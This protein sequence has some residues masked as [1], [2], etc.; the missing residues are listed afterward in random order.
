MTSN[1]SSNKTKA[2]V[3]RDVT[4]SVGLQSELVEE[5]AGTQAAFHESEERFRSAFDH[6]A[7]GMAIV[8]LDGRWIQVNRAIC[9]IVG[10]SEAELL[11]TNFQSITHPDD[12]DSNLEL[13]DQLIAGQIEDYQ[14][15]KRYF[16]KQGHI[17]WAL[18]SVSLVRD[19][20]GC[21]LYF[22]SQIQDITELQKTEALRKSEED[23]RTI[24]ELN[25]VGMMDADVM[26]RRFL[27]VNRKFCE[28]TGYSSEELLG[29]TIDQ[30]THP[31]DLAISLEAAGQ[32]LGGEIKSRTLEK[33]YIRKDGG[34]IWGLVNIAIIR[35]TPGSPLRA[36]A[37]VQDITRRKLSEE[38]ESGRRKILE[39]LIKGA[40]LPV[41]L[42]E[43]VLTLERQVLGT[44]AAFLPLTDGN[45]SVTGANLPRALLDQLSQWTLSRSI[46]LSAVAWSSENHCGHFLLQSDPLWTDCET[47]ARQNHLHSVWC[48]PIVA[49][50]GP[51]GLLLLF[52]GFSRRPLPHEVDSIDAANKLLTVCLEH[53]HASAGLAKAKEAAESAS[54]AKTQFL[55]HMSHEIRTPLTAIL[56]FADLVLTPESREDP[57]EFAHTV[58]RNGEHLLAIINDILD[59]SKIE[60]GQLSIEQVPTNIPLLLGELVPLMRQRACM[61]G[62]SLDVHF[63][64]GVPETIKSD[65]TRIR[66]ILLNLLGN[67]IKFTDHGG[68][69]I[70]LRIDESTEAFPML[71]IDIQDT[72]IGMTPEQSSRV[73]ASF[74]QADT[75]H[76]RLYGGTGLG[77]SISRRLANLM[78]GDIQVTTTTHVGST[79]TLSIPAI[80]LNGGRRVNEIETVAVADDSNPNSRPAGNSKRCVG[81]ILLAEDSPANQRLIATYLRNAGATV[82]IVENGRAAIESAT[83]ALRGGAPYDLILMDCQMPEMDGYAATRALRQGG[84]DRPIVAL[85]AHAMSHDRDQCLAAGSND[86][87]TKPLQLETFFQVVERHVNKLPRSLPTSPPPQPA[88]DVTNRIYSE[89]GDHPLIGPLIEQYLIGLQNKVQAVIQAVSSRDLNVVSA[90]AHQIKGDAGSYGFPSITRA[91]QVVEEIAKSGRTMEIVSEAVG[92]LAEVCRQASV[93][94]P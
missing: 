74:V 89:L 72:G 56:G 5:S 31:E 13:V 54:A 75:S 9:K 50:G 29:L 36:V 80:P 48:S 55:A 90:L 28:M 51:H 19:K 91:A 88:S 14:M 84:Y 16:H 64:T 57:H 8:G 66:Q 41:L 93:K 94:T 52:S 23:Y 87:L 69:S 45:V 62:L 79:F 32:I 60:A 59:L 42:D 34:T 47:I 38:L 2:N 67:A 77:L 15:V 7:I 83:Q 68:V 22:I 65:P 70:H 53:H 17:V 58:K 43:F 86:F 92:R 20:K 61:K 11:A 18:L 37:S 24:F 3:L 35:T 46:G 44:T 30:L 4:E 10:R 82:D 63:V 39:L 12:L 21:P 78:G 40:P 73:F 1:A 6:A 25:G 76:A 26:T 49:G 85:T 71:I 33:R 81:R 27:R